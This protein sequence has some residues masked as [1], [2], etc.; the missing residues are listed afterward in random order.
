[1]SGLF[2][3][4]R[5]ADAKRKRL[6]IALLTWYEAN[7]RD[8]PWRRTRDPFR[9]WVSEIMLQQT[10]V[11]AVL[12]HYKRF[13]QQF[14]TV[15]ALA[16]AR[17]QEVLT[18]WSGLGYYRR[19]RML[20][21]A[22][23]EVLR[24]F[25]GRMPKT[26]AELQQLPGIGRYTAA[27]IASIAF[28]EPIAV[29]DGNVE[30]VLSR[31]SGRQ[32]GAPACW[33][34]AQTLVDPDHAGD[35]NQAMMELGATLCLPRSPVCG[36]CPIRRYCS[37]R[38]HLPS[39]KP[40]AAQTRAQRNLALVRRHNA[41]LLKQR[42]RSESVMPGLWD[43]PEHAGSAVNPV[44]HLKHSIMNTAYDV[45]VYAAESQ[46]DLLG[47]KWILLSRLRTIPLTGMSR[48]VL[49]RLNLLQ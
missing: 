9:I 18:A 15:F 5:A 23:K 10:R 26:S 13:F 6:R 47:T 2:S 39:S 17:E 19:A 34:E 48:K 28:R 43:L 16:K 30:R 8:L 20:H 36:R 40:K 14:P 49:R 4:S 46:L 42:S 32:L 44:L 29:V 38:G 22:A 25:K 45:R 3:R 41:I 11:A 35:F 31:I 21:R 1:M 7:K 24:D 33:Q 27:A 37:V 12:D